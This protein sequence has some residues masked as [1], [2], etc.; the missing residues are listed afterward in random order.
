MFHNVGKLI[1]HI[2]R[3]NE[4]CQDAAWE[5]YF[6]YTNI[7]VPEVYSGPRLT[8][9]LDANQAADLIEAFRNKQVGET[10]SNTECETFHSPF[11][12][13]CKTDYIE[14]HL[15]H[16]DL[17]LQSSSST[18]GM[19]SNFFLKPGSCSEFCQISTESLPAIA[20]KS[21]YVVRKLVPLSFL[22]YYL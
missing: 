11:I 1:S 4:I 5:R 16:I 3:E 8:F 10:H 6:R 2:F 21:Q 7:D 15:M 17:F 13:Y 18:L 12:M 22:K 19:F 9:P 14:L 20:K